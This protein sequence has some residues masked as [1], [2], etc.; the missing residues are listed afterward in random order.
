[1]LMAVE[2][3]KC[4]VKQPAPPGLQR[5][6]VKIR[7]QPGSSSPGIAG[8]PAVRNLALP[9]SMGLVLVLAGAGQTVPAGQAVPA[10]REAR[11]P[12]FS[13]P[14]SLPACCSPIA[15]VAGDFN[16]DQHVDLAALSFE[17]DQLH[18]WFRRSDGAFRGPVRLQAGR[19]VRSIAIA[20][21]NQ[22]GL[23]DL[24]TANRCPRSRLGE[25][26]RPGRWRGGEARSGA[27]EP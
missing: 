14:I 7:S 18:V 17:A 1:M 9:F 22:D 5:T 25:H 15:V 19:G 4:G 2:R 10:S 13:A 16:G 11:L 6:E 20:D 27:D 26:R 3:R 23:P 12:T 8:R 21:F 24:A